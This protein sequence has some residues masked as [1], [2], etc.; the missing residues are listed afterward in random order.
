MQNLLLPSF[1]YQSMPLVKTTCV[2]FFC[3]KILIKLIGFETYIWITHP[4][5]IQNNNT[6]LTLVKYSVSPTQLVALN[7]SSIMLNKNI[8]IYRN[9]YSIK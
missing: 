5:L 4:K 8:H 6:C 9:V 7:M 1:K 2:I 3:I